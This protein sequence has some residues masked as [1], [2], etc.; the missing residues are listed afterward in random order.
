MAGKSSRAPD[1]AEGGGLLWLWRSLSRRRC[2]SWWA[3]GGRMGAALSRTHF[4]ILWAT[5]RY[6]SVLSRGGGKPWDSRVARV[7]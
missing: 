1:T 5:L 7:R 2:A 3:G 4:T 6:P